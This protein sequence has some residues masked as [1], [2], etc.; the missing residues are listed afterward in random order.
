MSSNFLLKNMSLTRCAIVSGALTFLVPSTALAIPSPELVIGSVSSLSQIFAVGVAAITGAGA[1]AARRL[2]FSPLKP[3]AAL[4]FP[5]RLILGLILATM[6]FGVLNIWQYRAQNARELARLQATLVRPAQFDGTKIQD[7]DLVETSLAGQSKSPFALS[8]DDAVKLLQD[9]A[10]TNTTLFFDIRET[11]E[12]AMGTLPGARHVRYPDFLQS[13]IP[14]AGKQ[15]VLFCHNGNRSSETCAALAARGIDCRFI[16]GGIEKWIVEGREFSDKNVRSLSDLR[17]IPQYVNKNTLLGTSDFQK[18]LSSEDIQIV[19]TRYPGDFATGHL[20]GAFNIPV[21]ALPTEELKKRIANLQDK[22][23]VAACYDRRS[24]FMSQVLGLELSQ[25]G[26]VFRGRYTTPWEY[27]VRPEPKPHVKQWLA[28]QDA[29]PW[30][31]A[32]SKLADLLIWIGDQTHF[33]VGLISLSL[34]SRVLVLPIAL[35]SERDQIATAKYAADLKSLKER[36]KHDPARKARAIQK[37]YSDKGLTPMRNLVALLFL[38]V[39]MLGLGAVEKA[40]ASTSASFL[41]VTH[42]GVPDQTYLLPGLFALLAGI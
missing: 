17:A 2:G 3:D 30:Q 34:L 12:H 41:W 14:L 20:P 19:D 35:K 22:P 10:S 42:L 4:R 36:L 39:M 26:F 32:V 1:L 21:R 31:K 38:P 25:A 8:T 33:V 11:V 27:F 29:T 7:K 40:S 13:E 6:A 23:T 5:K 18:L 16:A 15:V 37:F 28:E 24:C 9:G